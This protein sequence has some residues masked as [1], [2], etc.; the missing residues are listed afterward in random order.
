MF[1]KK[2]EYSLLCVRLDKVVLK[3]SSWV[4]FQPQAM[5]VELCLLAT[6]ALSSLVLLTDESHSGPATTSSLHSIT[7]VSR[8]GFSS[9][10][11]S[12]SSGHHEAVSSPLLQHDGERCFVL[13]PVH[14]SPTTTRDALEDD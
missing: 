9:G 2:D 8:R 12:S 4:F 6:L 13:M 14:E 3:S 1:V 11:G 5:T 7:T 10:H